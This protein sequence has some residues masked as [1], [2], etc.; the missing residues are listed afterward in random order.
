MHHQSADGLWDMAMVVSLSYSVKYEL[1]G[2]A[3]MINKGRNLPICYLIMH[4]F[5]SWD[6]LSHVEII[7]IQY[8]VFILFTVT[9]FVNLPDLINIGLTIDE[10]K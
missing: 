1:V 2:N 9:I 8:M 10:Q 4:V 5:C 6:D 7:Q 3:I